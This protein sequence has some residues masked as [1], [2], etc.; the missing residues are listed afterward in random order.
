MAFEF[1]LN[2]PLLIH[3][4]IILASLFILFKA[5]D[6]IIFGIS[7]YAKKLGLSDYLIGL[8]V[9]AMAASM[10]EV[11]AALTGLLLDDQGVMLGAILGTNMVHLALVTGMLVLIGRKMSVECEILD[12]SLP[13]VWGFMLLPFVLMLDGT[14]SRIDGIILIAVFGVYIVNLWRQEGTLGRIKKDVKLR[15][16]WRDGAVFIGSLIALLLAGMYFV[17]STVELS[18]I[19]GIPTFFIALTVIAVASA[20]PDFA[21]GIRAVLGGHQDIGI[22][23]VLGSTLIEFLLFFG[24]VALVKPLEVDVAGLLSSFIFLAV[25]STALMYFIYKKRIDWRHGLFMVAL[26]L[27]FIGVELYKILR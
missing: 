6:L 11:I 7:N 4:L 24:V 8:V 20:L 9:V 5:A 1:I 23:D 17:R 26:Y 21:V 3:P 27:A 15:T 10:P 19:A 14:L 16:L 13:L 12:K 18:H 22:G 2:Q 25:A